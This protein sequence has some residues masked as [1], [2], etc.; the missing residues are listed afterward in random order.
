MAR[1][2]KHRSRAAA[3]LAV[4]VLLLLAACARTPPEQRLRETVE[5][6]Q[7]AIA[8]RNVSAMD[9]VLA[10]DFIGPGGL[11][12]A[13]AKR[14]A[15]AMFLR[16]RDVGVTLGPLDIHV[17]GKHATVEFSAAI[18]GGAGMLPDSGQVYDVATGWRFEDGG[19]QL[20]NASWKPGL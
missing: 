5:V 12:R 15:R 1:S 13:G 8:E 14:M 3:W 4:C 9:D 2:N 10:P 11:D 6:L 16:Y 18:T 17:Q 20:V 19:W 7:V